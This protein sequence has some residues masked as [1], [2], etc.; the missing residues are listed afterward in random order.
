MDIKI[1]GTPHD[2]MVLTSV[3][4]YD[5]LGENL[6]MHQA[7]FDL[8]VPFDDSHKKLHANTRSELTA[9]LKRALD[10]LENSNS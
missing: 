10:D 1:S 3:Y 7:Q 8:W 9:F 6:P 4:L 2:G 5:D